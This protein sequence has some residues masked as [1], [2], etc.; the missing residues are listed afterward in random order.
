LVH[1]YF[2]NATSGISLDDLPR[3][4]DAKALTRI[5]PFSDR[6]REMNLSGLSFLHQ[7]HGASGQEVTPKAQPKNFVDEGDYLITRM[8]GMGIGVL[9]ADCLPVICID[10]EHSAIGIAHAGWRGAVAGVHLEMMRAM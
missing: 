1:S 10:Q 9:T 7:V 4:G 3:G 8:P 6:A 2:G 5:D